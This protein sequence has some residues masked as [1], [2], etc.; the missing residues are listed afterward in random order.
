MCGD[1]AQLGSS[2]ERQWRRWGENGGW[3]GPP[4]STGSISAGSEAE[5]GVCQ[6]GGQVFPLDPQGC[7]PFLPPSLPP[8]S[9]HPLLLFLPHLF[10]SPPPFSPSS[11]STFSFKKKKTVTETS[12]IPLQCD[13]L[14]WYHFL[15]YLP[16]TWLMEPAARAAVPHRRR[17]HCC[18]SPRNGLAG[19]GGGTGTPPCSV[20]SWDHLPGPTSSVHLRP[21]SEGEEDGA[22]LRA[23]SAGTQHSPGFASGVSGRRPHTQS[24]LKFSSL[25]LVPPLLPHSFQQRGTKLSPGCVFVCVRAQTAWGQGGWVLGSLGNLPE[26]VVGAPAA[27]GRL[28]QGSGLRG[29][30][31]RPADPLSGPVSSAWE[32]LG[33]WVAWCRIYRLQAPGDVCSLCYLLAQPA[34]LFLSPLLTPQTAQV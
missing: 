14:P 4:P 23:E 18:L 10:P 25:T 21:W 24:C 16:P 5:S 2:W 8:S 29:S 1:K 20:A 22:W 15:L 32:R 7:W 3:A 13:Q 11:S 12:I 26:C 34:C 19:E 9:P 27:A 30:S 28:S 33:L 17:C 31:T 6:G